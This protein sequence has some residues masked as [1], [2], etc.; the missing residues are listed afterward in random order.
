MFAL[1]GAERQDE[2]PGMTSALETNHRL[3][4]E[5]LFDKKC[6]NLVLAC[7]MAWLLAHVDLFRG[8]FGQGEDAIMDETVVHEDIGGANALGGAQ[9]EEAGIARTGAD[10]NHFSGLVD[11]R[12]RRRRFRF[13]FRR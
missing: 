7:V 2:T 12:G 10:Q 9:G 5:R 3:A 13:C 6:V 8:G 1:S 11:A 4:L